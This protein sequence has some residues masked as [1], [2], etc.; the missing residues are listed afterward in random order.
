[1]SFIKAE[2]AVLKPILNFA[3]IKKNLFQSKSSIYILRNAHLIKINT[4]EQI[5]YLEYLKVMKVLFTN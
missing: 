5:M 2:R 3:G 4:E 1:M